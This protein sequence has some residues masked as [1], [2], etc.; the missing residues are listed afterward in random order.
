MDLKATLLQVMSEYTGKGWNNYSHLMID[1]AAN[2]FVDVTI[3]HDRSGRH[4]FADL[5]V[6]LVDDQIIIE[7]DRNDKTLLDALLQAGVPRENIIVAYAGEPVPQTADV[8]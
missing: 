3:G 2:Y 5:I 6:R 1:H 8:L 4:A 7:Q